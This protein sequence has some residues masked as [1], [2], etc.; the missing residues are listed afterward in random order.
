MKNK[1]QEALRR[2]MKLHHRQSPWRLSTAGVY[3][4]HD[5]SEGRTVSWWDDFGFVLAGRRVMVWW[6]HPRQQYADEIAVVARQQA[7]EPPPSVGEFAQGEKI[8]KKVGRSRKKVAM[9]RMTPF[10]AESRAYYAQLRSIETGLQ[11]VGIDFTVLPSLQLKWRDWCLGVELC[12]PVELR[13]EADVTALAQWVRRVLQG[14][15][16]LAAEYGDYQYGRV[17]W[18]AEA[19]LRQRVKE[20]QD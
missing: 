5:Y 18:L 20:E 9:Y 13:N 14:E 1:Y 6:Q 19:A 15:T 7:G 12:V 11:E 17:E 8:W 3:I 16:S 4:P 2:Q 10:P